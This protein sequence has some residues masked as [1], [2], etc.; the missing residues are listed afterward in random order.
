MKVGLEGLDIP[1]GRRYFEIL[2]MKPKSLKGLG[3][4]SGNHRDLTGNRSEDVIGKI[5][6]G[7]I[8]GKAAYFLFLFEIWD[9]FFMFGFGFCCVGQL[10]SLI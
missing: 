1:S 2:D 6:R 8:K 3:I 4:P 5:K 10:F 7:K 9:I